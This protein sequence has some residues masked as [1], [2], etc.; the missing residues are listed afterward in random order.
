MVM[1]NVVLADAYAACERT[2]REHYENFPVAS[3]LVPARMRRHI[4]AV[5]AFARAADDFADEGTRTDSERLSLL[6]G[7]CVRLRAAAAGS[8]INAPPAVGEPAAT[9]EI[10]VA[11][12]AT[13][14]E[15]S[16]PVQLFEDLLSAFRQDVT[17]RRYDTWANLLDYCRRSANPVGRLVLRIAGHVDEQLDTWSDAICTALQLTNFWQDLDVDWRRG[18]LYVPADVRRMHGDDMRGHAAVR[19]TA[20]PP[21]PA[22]AL[23][24]V[25]DRTR[26]LFDAGRP[27][28]DVVR[29][30][31]RYE[32]RATWL[33]GVRILDRVSTRI[34]VNGSTRP[35]LGA[36]D[37]PWLVWHLLSWR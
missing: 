24:D 34:A 15:R 17:V 26:A 4:A 9:N 12:G 2:A 25:V 19:A 32:L 10:F 8:P 6:D 13:I 28:C 14:R 18:R 20:A 37:A 11:L 27:L 31:L 22:S 29:G 33:G 21:V 35:S 3:L 16:L 1:P 30:R 5:Y 23:L 36:F 7:W